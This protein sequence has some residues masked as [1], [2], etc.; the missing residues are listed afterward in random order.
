MVLTNLDTDT[1]NAENLS[2]KLVEEQMGRGFG[3]RGAGGG[4]NPKTLGPNQVQ[5]HLPTHSREVS[6]RI[7]VNGVAPFS[8][9]IMVRRKA[10]GVLEFA[11]TTE[12]SR[13]GNFGERVQRQ[14]RHY[15][16]EVRTTAMNRT[17]LIGSYVLHIN[18]TEIRSA[19]S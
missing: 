2:K 7:S 17:A 9:M 3:K 15:G 16:V 13:L 12:Q 6:R 5:G 14:S 18:V 10:N 19:R 11:Q 1:S 8:G 4:K